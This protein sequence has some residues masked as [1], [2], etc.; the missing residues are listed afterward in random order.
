MEHSF[1]LL[2]KN[3][4]LNNEQE[5][6]VLSTRFIFHLPVQSGSKLLF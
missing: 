6:P 1:L 4:Y 5:N 2:N 3:Q